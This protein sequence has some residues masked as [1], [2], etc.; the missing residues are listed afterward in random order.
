MSARARPAFAAED[1]LELGLFEDERVELPS[2]VVQMSPGSASL[3]GS[4]R[5]GPPIRLT[6]RLALGTFCSPCSLNRAKNSK[7][8]K[9]VSWR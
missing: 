9:G 1:I 2:G 8:S 7:T 4:G 6:Q 5:T 3:T